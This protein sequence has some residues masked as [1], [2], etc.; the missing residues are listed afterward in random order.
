MRST[1]FNVSFPNQ[2][3][4]LMD[5]VAGEESRS[6]SDL[7]RE[8]VREYV[9]RK[10]RWQAVFAFGRRQTKQ[11]RFRPSD[12]EKQITDYRRSKTG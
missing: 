4:K 12:I 3:V 7:L 10:K 8:A 2:L 11:F 5:R 6:R 1:T 9:E